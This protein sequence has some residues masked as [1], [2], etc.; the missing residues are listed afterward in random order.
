MPTAP[1]TIHDVSTMDL[2]DRSAVLRRELADVI[3]HSRA[4]LAAGRERRLTS[5]YERLRPIRG[6]SDA[7]LIA[8]LIADARL[9]L[10]CIARKT[11]VPAE[12]ADGLLTT[13]AKTLRLK[14]GPN[15]CDA[16]LRRRTTFSVT[17]DGQP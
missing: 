14:R 15:R 16:C 7:A 9:C 3:G 17:K 6:G 1:M 13:F 10:P 4:L 2:L 11:G 5:T 8:A 12:Q